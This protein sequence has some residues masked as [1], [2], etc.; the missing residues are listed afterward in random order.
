M[1]M[2]RDN[3]GGGGRV[4]KIEIQLKISSENSFK[5]VNLPSTTEAAGKKAKILK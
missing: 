3:A 2:R 1:E 4:G 5:P